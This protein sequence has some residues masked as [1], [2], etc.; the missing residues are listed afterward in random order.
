MSPVTIIQTILVVALGAAVLLVRH[1][2]GAYRAAYG[3]IWLAYVAHIGSA[4]AQVLLIQYVYGG[5]DAVFYLQRGAEWARLLSYDSSLYLGDVVGIVLQREDVF[6]PA[7]VT[8]FGT[9]T[10]TMQG[11]TAILCWLLS[12]SLLVVGMVS[13]VLAFHGQLAIYNVAVARLREVSP[14][15]LAAAVLLVPSAVFWT[16]SLVK[17][18][19]ATAFLGALVSA[20]HHLLRGR[21]MRSTPGLAVGAL[22]L[23]LVKPYVLFAFVISAV[24]WWYWEQALKR[25]GGRRMEIRPGALV[26]G[27]LGCSLL[28]IV[29]GRLFPRYAL[30]RVVEEAARLQAVGATTGGGSD[31]ALAATTS[32]SAAGQFVLAPLAAFTA[33]Y[34]PLLIEV[35]NPLALIAALENTAFL[36][37]TVSVIWRRG[38][39]QTLVRV[40]ENP[41]L[42]FSAVLVAILAVAVGLASTNLGTLSRYRVPLVPFFALLLLVSYRATAAGASATPRS[43]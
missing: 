34:R 24:A 23:G 36:G 12:P 35:H 4:V 32:A 2:A 39:R 15:A 1:R 33:L 28:L 29:L 3:L 40:A 26:L 42:V 11:L 13:S 27:F 10:A 8:K 38:L 19:I 37:L 31:Y 14:R 6:L 9:S 18:A 41:L 21:P 22:G 17:E 5:G 20:F 16:S 7:T 25:S 43:G 30:E